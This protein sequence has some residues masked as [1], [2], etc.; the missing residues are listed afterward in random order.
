MGA[1]VAPP[2]PAF[3]N[4]P[5]TIDDLLNHLVGRMLDLFEIDAGIVRRWMGPPP[6][7][8]REARQANMSATDGDNTLS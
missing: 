4:R 1:I 8:A 5:E 2:V 6:L 7:N 3:Y